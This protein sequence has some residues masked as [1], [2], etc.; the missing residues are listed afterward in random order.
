[1][2]PLTAGVRRAYHALMAMICHCKAV[3]DRAIVKAVQRGATS[4]RAVQ[5]SC[6]ANTMCGGCEPAV[7]EIIEQVTAAADGKH[8]KVGPA[9]GLS[10]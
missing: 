2:P 6:G 1:M 4:M 3:R 9:F 5:E 7:A 8:R 10:A